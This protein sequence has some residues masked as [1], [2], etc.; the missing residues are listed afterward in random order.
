MLLMQR[1]L[2]LMPC[3]LL[4]LSCFSTP[5]LA[6]EEIGGEVSLDVP[7]IM[8][9]RILPDGSLMALTAEKG[10]LYR[11]KPGG[12]GWQKVSAPES[13][14][15]H[16]TEH[17]DGTL[18]LASDDG[19]FRLGG[20]S[21]ARV[22]LDPVAFVQFSP[23]GK[24][25][26]VKAWGRGL[27]RLP[28]ADLTPEALE[29]WE[30]PARRQ[31]ELKNL[32]QELVTQMG[33]L[34]KRENASLE[35]KRR[36]ADFFQKWQAVHNEIEVVR[37]QL[38]TAP[39]ALP[40]AL[41][42]ASVTSAV[43]TSD[44]VWMVGTFGHG[45][46]GAGPDARDWSSQSTGLVSRRITTLARA[47]WGTLYAGA[48][49]AGL[50]AWRPGSAAWVQVAP[51]LGKRVVLDM[52]FGPQGEWAVATPD[53][54]VFVSLDQG[55]NWR[56][57]P[58]AAG[59]SVQ[60][61]AIGATGVIWAGTWNGG[62][63]ASTDHGRSWRHRPFAGEKKV[64]GMTFAQD[65]TGYAL[66]AG[67][68]LV[69]SDDGGRHWFS[70]SLPVRP[71]E[72]VRLAVDKNGDVL[73]A[74][75][76]NGL[77]RSA[78]RGVTWTTDMHGLPDGGVRDVAVSPTGLTLAVPAKATGLFLRSRQGEWQLLPMV[79][80]DGW[81]YSVWKTLFLPDG[82]YLAF[83]Y[84]DLVMSV[85]S[86]QTWRRKRFG[87]PFRS[88]AVDLTG[89]IFTERMLSTFVLRQRSDTQDWTEGWDEVRQIPAEAFVAFAPV[90]GNLWLGAGYR[91]GL[92]LLHVH[93]GTMSAIWNR[94]P[95]QKIIALAAHPNGAIFVG[96]EDG[97]MV[98]QDLGRTWDKV[99]F[100]IDD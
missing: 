74:S 80:E 23:D 1:L 38:Q 85:D 49:G 45:V 93:N 31:G 24:Q 8:Q 95:G 86:G 41:S 79:G 20:Q 16:L 61:V 34:S 97:L 22:L 47:P 73:L 10:G 35:E 96:L 39:L 60:S 99:A 46:W 65:G 3:A 98:S 55:R 89:E 90:K 42:R 51:E 44:G 68:G 12:M 78:D 21:W 81:N 52:A 56:G 30:N 40:G 9:V 18:Y 2:K 4:L 27:Y 14:L 25:A 32:S 58:V 91:G 76:Q 59:M 17:P 6:G 54:G 94:F 7:G 48:Y 67:R 33:A 64:V 66:L 84:Q 92:W 28:T 19:L 53:E 43:M 88:L 11:T 29:R 83:G 37:E 63:Y 87:Q 57:G 26:L 82:R 71:A 36:Q 15:H 75:P 62:L 70:L 50:W 100:D 77:W 13:F 5:V 69:R 72:N